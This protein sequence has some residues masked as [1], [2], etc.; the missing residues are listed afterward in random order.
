MEDALGELRN[1]ATEY[2]RIPRAWTDLRELG[3]SNWI[4]LAK[5]ADLNNRLA[6]GRLCDRRLQPAAARHAVL[7]RLDISIIDS[8]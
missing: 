7:Y 6:T 1:L 4:P 5:Y 3:F 2:D 8:R